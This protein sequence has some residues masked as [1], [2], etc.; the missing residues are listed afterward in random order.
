MYR[1]NIL[2]LFSRGFNRISLFYSRSILHFYN[3]LKFK[4][5]GVLFK[6]KPQLYGSCSVGIDRKA[7]VSIGENFHLVSNSL[8][9]PLCRSKSCFRVAANGQLII[10]NNVGM[11]SPIIW[12]RK[13]VII[14]N[15]V[16]LGGGT[17]IFDSDA[18]S[19]NFLHRR[20]GVVDMANRIDKE[21]II[22]DDVLIG[23]N[24][25]VLKGVRIGARSIIG[26]GSIVTKDIP[27]DCIAAGNPAIVIKNLKQC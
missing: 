10:G 23:T 27:S 21:I 14:G 24:C 3:T 6:G 18:H 25:I 5:Q 22:G 17:I 9:N 2:S 4:G 19:L 8:I 15:H 20:D 1:L 7:H 26:A 16:N 12:V 11:S 13:S